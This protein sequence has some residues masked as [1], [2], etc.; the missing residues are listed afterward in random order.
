MPITLNY[1]IT[2]I[3]VA[4]GPAGLKLPLAL[5]CSIGICQLPSSVF[6]LMLSL[7]FLLSGRT[8]SS[9]GATGPFRAFPKSLSVDFGGLNHPQHQ[10][11]PQSVSQQQHQTA[12]PFNSSNAQDRYA[13][14]SH[15]DSVFCD[16]PSA[17]GTSFEC[18]GFYFETDAHIDLI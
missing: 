12:P 1:R 18:I 8:V 16:P 6:A 5:E 2:Y 15:L 14:V 4:A 13:A 9:S 17:T 3:I 7:V 10:S 11:L